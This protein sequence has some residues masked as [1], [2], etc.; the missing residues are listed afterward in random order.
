VGEGATPCSPHEAQRINAYLRALIA[1][2]VGADAARR[3]RL[4]YTGSV[5]EMNAADYASL[6]DV[7]G[8]VV[9]RA[10]LEMAKLRSIIQ[11]LADSA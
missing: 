1:K 11:T 3:C 7:E 5:N 10:G 6:E 8:F 4:T 9:G 2:R